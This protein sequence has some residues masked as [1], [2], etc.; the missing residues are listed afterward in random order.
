MMVRPTIVPRAAK[1]VVLAAAPHAYG[2]RA[3]TAALPRPSTAAMRSSGIAASVKP[4]VKWVAEASA[5]VAASAAIAV[6][7]FRLGALP[8]WGARLMLS[9]PASGAGVI[10]APRG[11]LAAGPPGRVIALP[12][13]ASC[14]GVPPGGPGAARPG[15][16]RPRQRREGSA[17]G[18]EV[19]RKPRA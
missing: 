6:P 19:R 2:S 8:L 17:A 16:R 18:W 15:L 7:V 14:P 9:S 10:G 5:K 12:G 1:L 4:T 13:R 3:R 11:V